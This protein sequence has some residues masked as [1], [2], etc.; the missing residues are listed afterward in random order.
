MEQLVDV[1]KVLDAAGFEGIGLTH[2]VALPTT[3]ESKYPYTSDGQFEWD[4]AMD[5]PDVWVTAPVLTRATKHLRVA[6]AVFVAPMQDP[7]TL[8]K[9]LSTAAYFCDGRLIFGVG[10][11]WMAEEFAL[12]GQPFDA[13]GRRL[14]ELLEVLDKL[15]SGE[16]VEHSGR[17]YNFESVRLARPVPKSRVPVYVAGYG[18]AAMDR[19][20]RADGWFAPG[21]VT[22]GVMLERLAHLRAVREEAGADGPFEAIMAVI[23]MPSPAE[24]EEL[25]GNGATSV[26][27]VP[28]LGT[29]GTLDDRRRLIEAAAERASVTARTQQNA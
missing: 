14:D 17:Y 15:L 21:P 22:V 23:E 1:A 25:E 7:F 6:P 10:A 28:M 5:V 12:T 27:F 26:M 16:T 4:R 24:L 3:I 13:R 18:R 19:A 2:H 29:G 8:A 11:G 9:A 20:T